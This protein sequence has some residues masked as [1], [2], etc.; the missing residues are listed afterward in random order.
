M[1]PMETIGF[2]KQLV[3]GHINRTVL[4]KQLCKI[5]RTNRKT[6]R[7][8][9]KRYK[10]HGIK[11]LEELSRAPKRIWNKVARWIECLV[12]N[13][14]KQGI[15]P[16]EIWQAL[17]NHICEKTVYNIL[18]RNKLFGRYKPK[19]PY[20]RYEYKKPNQLWHVDITKFKVKKQGRFY[21]FAAIDDYSRYLVYI[22]V[23]RRMRSR[24]AI[25]FLDR[26]FRKHGYPE[27]MLTDCGRQFI[28]KELKDWLPEQVKHR[29]TRPWNPKC[30]GKIERWFRDLKDY[31]RQ[32]WY[33][34]A[35]E[36]AEAINRFV[37]EYNVKPK[38]VLNWKRPVERYLE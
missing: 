6:I 31:L 34:N 18:H 3:L 10:K 27:A 26:A 2:R 22:A 9:V 21:I 20:I 5:F 13:L 33:N 14:Y 7:K 36:L 1:L 15:K 30:N 37:Q 32:Y 28:S 25:D 12:C 29:K 8:W 4:V 11:G 24:E 19:Q 38:R 16:T 23:Y 17:K 35:N